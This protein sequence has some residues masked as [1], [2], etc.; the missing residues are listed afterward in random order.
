M[1]PALGLDYGDA[2]IGVAATDPLGILAH[3]VETIELATTNTVERIAEI[4]SA[5]GVATLVVGLPLNLDGEEGP[6]AEKAR[7]FAA[8]I[9]ARLPDLPLVFVDESHTTVDAS[10]KL[11]EAG[12]NAKRQKS[13]IDQAAAVEILNRWLETTLPPLP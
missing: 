5:R 9:S 6:A 4:C 12:R 13:V 2:R 1:H 10:A 3:P 11:R 8:K 7:A